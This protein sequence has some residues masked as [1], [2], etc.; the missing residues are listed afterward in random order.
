MKTRIFALLTALVLVCCAFAGCQTEKTDSNSNQG[1]SSAEETS[2]SEG[3]SAREYLV[4]AVETQMLPAMKELEAQD[5]EY[6]NVK[7]TY[8]TTDA[9]GNDI[10]A[11]YDYNK[12]SESGKSSGEFTVKT[13]EEAFNSKFVSDGTDTYFTAPSL[14]EKP[15]MN[16]TSGNIVEDDFLLSMLLGSSDEEE[17]DEEDEDDEAGFAEAL[18]CYWD[19]LK[20]G[21]LDSLFTKSQGDITI[22]NY[23]FKD[24]EIITFDLTDDKAKEAIGADYDKKLDN[25]DVEIKAEFVIENEKMSAIKASLKANDDKKGADIDIEYSINGADV[26]LTATED[27]ETAFSLKLMHNNVEDNINGKLEITA[28]E[29]ENNELLGE[30]VSDLTLTIN[31]K[32]GKG[33]MEMKMVAQYDES[34]DAGIAVPYATAEMTSAE[35]AFTIE[36]NYGKDENGAYYFGI[37]KIKT[38]VMGIEVTMDAVIKYTIKPIENGLEIVIHS[39]ITMMGMSEIE[40][41]TLVITEID[42]FEAEIPAD[43]DDIWDVEE[44]VSYSLYQSTPTIAEFFGFINI[45]DMWDDIFGEYIVIDDGNNRYSLDLTTNCGSYSTTFTLTENTNNGEK[46][47]WT[48]ADGTVAEFSCENVVWDSE[49]GSMTIDGKEFEIYDIPADEFG[50]A[51]IDISCYDANANVFIYYYPDTQTGDIYADFTFISNGDTYMFSYL[52]GIVQK[53]IL[54]DEETGDYYFAE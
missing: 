31:Y 6:Y 38:T 47:V 30:T 15:I 14:G 43:F 22:R 23:Q 26:D 54:Q 9:Y 36:F 11:E 34:A 46:V 7:G 51:Y 20:E 28:H 21:K 53:T 5:K 41:K 48:L 32:N 37:D 16:L 3:T 18:D 49:S 2:K 39:E 24:V 12:M 13:G 33:T 10:T 29:E 42:A 17:D 35:T 4:N 45:D 50:D 52:N 44:D 19:Y 1:A 40:D 8:V 25:V 27:G